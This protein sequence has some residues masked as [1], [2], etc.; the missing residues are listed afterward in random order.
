MALTNLT[1]IV[2]HPV[3]SSRKTN[4]DF[5]IDSGA[6]YSVVPG[7]VL[8]KLG[9]RPDQEREFILANGKKIK[10][11]LGTARFEYAGRKGGATVIFG[12]PGDS[13][14]LGATT[15]EALGFALN[16][17]K[18]DLMPLPMVLG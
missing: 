13:A 2:S 16:P 10:R 17:L 6:I 11:K 8:A 3:D 4:L 15:L 18:R 7:R 1:L 5:L 14:L 9:L 12:Q